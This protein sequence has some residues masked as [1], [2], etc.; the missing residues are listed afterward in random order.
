M[1]VTLLSLYEKASYL[2]SMRVIAGNGGMSNIV[3]WVHTVED[4]EVSEFL[5][6]GELIFSTGI[7]N[8][9]KDWLLPFVK[10]LIEKQ[11]SGLVINI[12]P[13][14]TEIPQK[15]IDYCNKMDFPLMDIP[16]K[17]RIVDISRDFCNQIILNEKQEEDISQTFKNM[18]FFPG[19]I[20]KYMPFLQS[21]NF[22]VNAN[23]CLIAVKIEL[24]DGVVLDKA[25]KI[26]ER[27]IYSFKKHWGEFK[28]DNVGYYVLCDFTSEEIESLVSKIQAQQYNNLSIQRIY[29]AVGLTN[30][31]V[32][33]LAKNYQITSRLI[34]ISIKNNISPEYYDKLGI[35]KILLSVDD[36]EIL[37]SFYK[38]NLS[39]LKIYDK[40]N[41][42]DYMNFLKM[43]LEYDGSVQK[44][45]EKTF[46][47]R[48]TIN[49]Q[50]LKVKKI[51]G[52]DIKTLEDRL[53]LLLA[54]QIDT[55][56]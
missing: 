37:K 23:Y 2:Y 29:V 48:N 13:Y 39:N 10:N 1:A 45:A 30:R 26:V 41:G 9:D 5:H 3:Q 20:E 56:L 27:I 42:T 6:G 7:A 49:Y 32:Q 34:T 17:T 14:I 28:V 12:G 16:W 18:I 44:V 47:H 55:L 21:H 33:F 25:E 46:V 36:T 24:Q 8:K 35:K 40:E 53:K 52:N 11:V 51:L 31:K 19:E 38:E 50:L 4:S 22:K 54:F 15:V 43:Y